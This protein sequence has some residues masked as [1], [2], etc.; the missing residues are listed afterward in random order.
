M[1][2]LAERE[3]LIARQ[4][5][6]AEMALRTADPRVARIHRQFASLYAARLAAS[7]TI[8]RSRTHLRLV[9]AN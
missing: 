9:V 8:I 3:Y 6:S 4:R 7:G 5:K 2:Q 1:Q